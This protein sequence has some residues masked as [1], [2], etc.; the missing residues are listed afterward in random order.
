MGWTS[1]NTGMV[2]GRRRCVCIY[3]LGGGLYSKSTHKWSF[4]NIWLMQILAGRPNNLAIH[5]PHQVG[6]FSNYYFFIEK[7]RAKWQKEKGLDLDT[8]TAPDT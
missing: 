3:S 6:M 1:E 2:E 7:G 4:K 8:A 5:M